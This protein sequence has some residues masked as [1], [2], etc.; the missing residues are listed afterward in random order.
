MPPMGSSLSQAALSNMQPRHG[1]GGDAMSAALQQFLEANNRTIQQLVQTVQKLQQAQAEQAASAQQQV[2]NTVTDMANRITAQAEE[3]KARKERSADIKEQRDY[4]M[5]VAEYQNKLQ[6][7]AAK[8]AQLVA[9]QQEEQTAAANR[10]L[11]EWERQSKT[12]PATNEY[13]RQVVGMLDELGHWDNIPDGLQMRRQLLHDLAASEAWN[14]NHFASPYADRVASTLSRTMQAI[15]KGEPYE[16]LTGVRPDPGMVPIRADV[17]QDIGI[18]LPTYSEEELAKIRNRSGYPPNGVFSLETDDPA[19]KLVSP[20]TYSFL[21]RMRADDEINNFLTMSQA[22]KE[23][24]EGQAR[25]AL[26]DEETLAGLEAVAMK[27]LDIYKGMAPGA[28]ETGLGD[29]IAGARMSAVPPE[30]ALTHRILTHLFSA[31]KPEYANMAL[32]LT[33]PRNPTKLEGMEGY[34]DGAVMSAG[35]RSVREYI[36]GVMEQDDNGGLG[37][38]IL[39]AA[40]SQPDVLQNLG[41]PQRDIAAIAGGGAG[42]QA[43]AIRRALWRLTGRVNAEVSSMI[44]EL[45]SQGPVRQFRDEL[46]TT[47]R[48]L[49]TYRVRHQALQSPEYQ[50]EQRSRTIPGSDMQNIMQLDLG[51]GFAR[52]MS[53][54]EALGFIY[55]DKPDKAAVL[56]D[57]MTAG[58]T[59]LK[60]PSFDAHKGALDWAAERD[61][62]TQ[63]RIAKIDESMR[64]LEARMDQAKQQSEAQKPQPSSGLSSAAMQAPSP[65][66]APAPQPSP[67]AGAGAG[68]GMKAPLA[69]P[70]PKPI[71]PPQPQGTGQPAPA[72]SGGFNPGPAAPLPSPQSP[73]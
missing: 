69:P 50:A 24:L 36:T 43:V 10:Y 29:W 35:L 65:G 18:D 13:Y 70:M 30:K 39:D 63:R 4:A 47:V 17:I 9:Q 8:D 57:Y 58:E 7:Q 68:G 1:G 22:Q 46:S 15:T 56:F 6:Q 16:D 72:Q 55:A 23:R 45:E 49:D 3:E 51:E 71:Q 54:L 19:W 73:Q 25:K 14:E 11:M 40:R 37:Q 12:I 21:M 48:V 60:S 61:P 62:F 53:N 42:A 59:G 66:Q 52:P 2:A 41:V 44:E 64:M 28:V 26:K 33:D 20:T 34:V 67:Q 27:S 31:T 5:D 32:R 38:F